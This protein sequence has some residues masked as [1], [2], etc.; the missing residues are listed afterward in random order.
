MKN[1]LVKVLMLVGV[2]LYTTIAN[3]TLITLDD[4]QGSSFRYQNLPVYTEAGFQVSVSCTNCINVISTTNASANFTNMTGA[5]GW[6]ANGRFLETWNSSAIFT[7]SA[8]SG[9]NFNFLGFD[10]G[11]YNNNNQNASWEVISLDS[12]NNP[13]IKQNVLGKG[14]VN[15]AMLGVSAVQFRNLSGFSSFDNLR[16]A[17]SLQS[18]SVPEPA[19][20][21][22]FGLALFGFA[23]R[24]LIK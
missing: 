24:R 16:V 11:W 9:E 17:S 22:I 19:T 7:L 5:I 4:L 8:I 21:T 2:L 3:A 13:L 1:T 6:G 12:A 15:F 18:T 20:L 23:A 10:M 14:S